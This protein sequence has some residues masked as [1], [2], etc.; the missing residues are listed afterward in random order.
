LKQHAVQRLD[1]GLAGVRYVFIPQLAGGLTGKR[2]P[3][4]AALIGEGKVGL[5]GKAVVDRNEAGSVGLGLAD[6]GTCLL[7]RTDAGGESML[8]A[9]P[10]NR[11][12]K[13]TRGPGRAPSSIDFCKARRRDGAP[14]MSRTPVTP[15]AI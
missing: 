11:P 12:A 10:R 2:E 13:T 4:L 6:Q 15:L 9:P 7:R 14:S 8:G 3:D 1:A 5:F